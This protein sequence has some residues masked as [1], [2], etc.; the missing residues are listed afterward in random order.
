MKYSVNRVVLFFLLSYNVAL[1]AQQESQFTQYMYNTS[2]INPAFAGSREVISVLVMHRSQWVGLDGAPVTNTLA[3]HS[4][5]DS[6]MKWGLGLSVVNDRLGPSDENTVSVDVSFAVPTSERF[7]LAFGLKSTLNFLNVNFNKLKEYNPA[8]PLHG[9]RNNIDNRFFPNLGFGVYWY[10]D[11]AYLGFSIPY[12][13]EKHYYDNNVQLTASERMHLHGMFGYVFSLDPKIKFKPAVLTKIV[14]G[15]PLQLD[16]SANFLFSEKLTLGA[17]Y[18][19]DAAV[20]ALAG[21]QISN[22]WLIGY[23]YDRDVTRLGN[24]NQGSHEIFLRYEFFRSYDRIKS[25]R[26]F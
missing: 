6:N 23:S 5:I 11:K 8:D 24:F 4:P 10:S 15:A 26:F 16:L 1:Y 20:S 14:K 21:F 17:A 13:L 2:S 25:P 7:K 9:S 19:W 22:T 12:L 18:R 3:V